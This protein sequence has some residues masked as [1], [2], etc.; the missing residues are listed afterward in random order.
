MEVAETAF[1]ASLVAGATDGE[2]VVQCHR[3][4]DAGDEEEEEGDDAHHKVEHRQR[5]G[6]ME[7][8]VAAAVQHGVRLLVLVEVPRHEEMG[9]VATGDGQVGANV[10]VVAAQEGRRLAEAK[11]EVEYVLL[12]FFLFIVRM[13]STE[14]KSTVVKKVCVVVVNV[15]RHR[16]PATFQR[17]P[18]NVFH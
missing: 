1:Q 2:A 14:V 7:Q 15:L 18:V 16:P 6:V 13:Q 3:A 10:V 11:V 12:C 5:I 8:V 4:A 9:S 17:L